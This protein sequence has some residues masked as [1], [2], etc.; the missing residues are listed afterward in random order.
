MATLRGHEN[1][2]KSVSFSK[3]GIILA[4]GSADATIKLWNIKAILEIENA[5]TRNKQKEIATLKG[6]EN[7]INVIAFQNEGIILASGSED[8]TIKL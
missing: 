4:S 8:K 6:H 2:I 5:E 3:D 1:V 7:G